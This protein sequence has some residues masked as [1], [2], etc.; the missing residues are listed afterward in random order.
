MKRIVATALLTLALTGAPAAQQADVAS[1]KDSQA[2]AATG[3]G[4]NP[5]GTPFSLIDLSR[6]KWSNSYSV[7]FFS[8]GGS[9]GSVGLWSTTMD[10]VIS[11]K[12]HLAINLGVLH[13]PG[14]LWGRAESEASFLPGFRLDYR[15]SDKV[16]MSLSVQ[17]GIGYYDPYYGRPYGGRWSPFLIE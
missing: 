15:P 7:A 9:S 14:S 10:Y 8:G 12:L 5:A 13:N 4:L 2:N 11:S 17:R 6:I 3:F 1:L 16:L